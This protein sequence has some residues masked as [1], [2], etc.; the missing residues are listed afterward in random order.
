MDRQD[1]LGRWTKHTKDLLSD[2][3][4]KVSVKHNENQLTDE[5]ILSARRGCPERHENHR[6]ASGDEQ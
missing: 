3:V 5:R 2:S 1:V 6:K 4:R